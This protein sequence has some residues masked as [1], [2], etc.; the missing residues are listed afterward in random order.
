MAIHFSWI[1]GLCRAGFSGGWW[2][3]N[4]TQITGSG[5]DFAKPLRLRAF[6]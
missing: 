3:S 6:A 1:I 5:F 4:L 2:L